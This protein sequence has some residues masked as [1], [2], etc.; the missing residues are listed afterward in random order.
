MNL[1]IVF[2]A[3]LLATA[4]PVPINNPGEWATAGDYPAEAL[5]DDKTG[6]VAF[7]LVVSPDGSPTQCRITESS[8]HPVLD[9]TTCEL[10]MARARFEPAS[11]AE[12]TSDNIYENRVR[13]NL[14]H[15]SFDIKNL[16]LKKAGQCSFILSSNGSGA[17][18]IALFQDQSLFSENRILVV[19]LNDSWAITDSDRIT[20]LVKVV[21]EGRSFWNKPQAID[22]GVLL[23]M[24]VIH[25]K[26]FAESNPRN[27][28]IYKG[29]LKIGQIDMR[30]FRAQYSELEK[31]SLREHQ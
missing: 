21:A 17:T 10:M 20:D 11:K 6:T 30:D 8:G 14:P 27:A 29:E 25:V 16:L 3:S 7:K 22:N 26:T 5:A 19:I 4:T 2:G 24:A 18:N 9:T 1:A 15:T 31:C 12:Y 23:F 13:W 28:T